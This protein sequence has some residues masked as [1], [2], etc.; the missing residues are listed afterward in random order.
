[1][2]KIVKGKFVE[3]LVEDVDNKLSMGSINQSLN[4][5]WLMDS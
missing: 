3:C 5:A 2:H 4:A 1:M